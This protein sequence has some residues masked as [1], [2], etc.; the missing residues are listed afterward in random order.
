M[1][2]LRG[3]QPVPVAAGAAWSAGL[4][5][6]RVRRGGLRS[7]AGCGP[8]PAPPVPP[9]PRRPDRCPPVPPPPLPPPVPPPGPAAGA[10]HPCRRRC[11]HRCRRP[12]RRRSRRPCR[13]L[14][15]AGRR[16][17]P[18]AGG[19]GAGATPVPVGGL[20]VGAPSVVLGRQLGGRARAARRS[21][22]EVV[23]VVVVVWRLLG[24][25]AGQDLQRLG[26][27][28]VPDDR[29]VG[30]ALDRL[31]VVQRWPS[32]RACRARRPTPRR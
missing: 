3:R 26:H 1:A 30:A 13:R 11:R 15:H 6:R 25:S 10:R 20:V 4:E 7:S 22:P 2:L 14:C 31:A 21:R 5:A 8:R 19:A 24:F 17:V 16:R 9:A 27:E 28:V 32:G 12:C 18:V 29:R 23:S